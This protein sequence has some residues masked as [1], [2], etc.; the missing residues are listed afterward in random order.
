MKY[1]TTPLFLL[2]VL[3]CSHS[4][5]SQ[6]SFSNGWNKITVNYDEK[7]RRHGYFEA[8]DSVQF[9]NGFGLDPLF[10]NS[11]GEFVIADL[12]VNSPAIKSK[13]FDFSDTIIAIDQ[14]N[15][16]FELKMLTEWETNKLLTQSNCELTF[17]IK[18]KSKNEEVK[19]D[20]SRYRKIL[21]REISYKGLTIKGQYLHGKMDGNWKIYDS[22]KNLIATLRYH[23]NKVLDCTGNCSD[24][25][26]IQDLNIPFGKFN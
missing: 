15:V 5:H 17:I 21:S 10:I 23:K 8:C 12:Y 1:L 16:R 7:G 20:A 14:N 24:V 25:Q 6:V 22:E 3:F 19:I 2:I 13:Q 11:T 26:F 4:S 9:I 18:H